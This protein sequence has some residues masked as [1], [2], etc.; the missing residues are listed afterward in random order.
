MLE[1]NIRM[2]NSV[3]GALRARP[4]E[5]AIYVSSDAVYKD[6]DRPLTEASCAEPGSLHGVIHLA[7]EHI[8]LDGAG[9][10]LGN[11]RPDWKL[12]GWGK[13][14]SVRVAHGVSRCI[15]TKANKKTN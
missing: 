1:R 8:P 10:P 13:S 7:R 9:V 5:H 14:M 4:V 3:V 12:V 15:K 6:S 11:L 2:M